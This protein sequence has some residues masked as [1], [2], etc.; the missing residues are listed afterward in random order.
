MK[1][2]AT[3]VG[4]DGVL[5]RL[6]RLQPK[7]DELLFAVT[8]KLTIDLQTYVKQKKLSGRPPG[9]LN[10]QTGLLR[11]SINAEVERIAP[12]VIQ[13][14]VGTNVIYARIHEFGGV[15]VPKNA[16]V[17][18][19]QIG[20]IDIFAKQVTIPE[21][22]FLRS[23]LAENRPKILQGFQQATEAFAKKWGTE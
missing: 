22:S 14:T 18:H 12:A 6:N 7:L 5:R 23:S 13:G 2:E 17:L 15:I 11:A 4:T 21:R 10:N 16:V 3:I 8:Q 9:A 19:F 1:I 20:G